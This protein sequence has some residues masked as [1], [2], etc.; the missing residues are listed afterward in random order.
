LPLTGPATRF[1]FSVAEAPLR[2]EADPDFDLF[3]RLSAEEIPP[4]VNTL[5]AAKETL[6]VLPDAAAPELEAAADLLVRS[7]GLQQARLV[8]ASA[9]SPERWR[10]R[11]LLWVGAMPPAGLLDL[12]PAEMALGTAEFSVAGRR[13][14]DPGETL[15][16]V[17]PQPHAAGAVV[18]V[19]LPLAQADAALV[20]RKI[21]HYG[22]TSY[23]VF[24]DGVNQAKGT[25]PAARS[26]V[27]HTWP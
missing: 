27:V 6:V 10:S 26:P 5:K 14:A 8:R 17:W 24:R 11:S 18:A 7:L 25:W 2:L 22:K 4:T 12:R 13:Y 23:L 1:S 15:F 19:F 3:R 21:T 9:L 20:A 16:A